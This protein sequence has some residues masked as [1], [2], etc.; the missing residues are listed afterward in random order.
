MASCARLR[1]PEARVTTLEPERDG[2][3]H[4]ALAAGIGGGAF[5]ARAG[6]HLAERCRV[7]EVDCRV[8]RRK[9]VP[10]E[11]VLEV[12][13]EGGRRAFFDPPFLRGGELAI[14]KTL[15]VK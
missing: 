5:I 7:G 15:A 11:R 10:L 3:V 6:R 13:P 4:Q 14:D 2:D 9:V 8:R 1:R 12:E